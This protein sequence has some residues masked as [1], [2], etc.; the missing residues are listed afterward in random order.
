MQC[1]YDET[2]TR[3]RATTVAVEISITYSEGV[4]VALGTQHG[5]RIRHI[6]I[7]GCPARQ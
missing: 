5:M 3:S 2:L 1:P 4:S 7:R 6:V